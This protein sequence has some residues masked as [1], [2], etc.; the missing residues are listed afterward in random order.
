MTSASSDATTTASS[1]A[2]SSGGYI[3]SGQTATV[4][5]GTTLTDA[6]IVGGGKLIVSGTASGTVL[7][8]TTAGRATEII[9][10]GGIENSVTI[11]AGIVSALSG[12][13]ITE[14]SVLSGGTLIF[15][16]GAQ[17]GTITAGSGG[18]VTISAA[19]IGTLE[20]ESGATATITS[21]TI[22]L[23]AI[24][25]A[26]LT[27]G[28]AT[29]AASLLVGPGGTLQLNGGTATGTVISGASASELILA[30]PTSGGPVETQFDIISGGSQT[31][32][33]GVSVASGTVDNGGTQ[34]VLSTASASHV[35]IASGG[36]QIISSGGI[37][38]DDQIEA[39]ASVLNNG[40]LIFDDQTTIQ[41]QISG[42]GLVEQT[43]AN[44]T[45]RFASGALAAFS[46][47]LSM[48][49]GTV[50]IADG[51]DAS[52]I[53]F[54]FTASG[55]ETLILGGSLPSTLA[56]S[57]FGSGDQIVLS[58]L[59][60]GTSADL[61]N[62][63]QLRIESGGTLIETI[64]LGSGLDYSAAG[65]TLT[66][67]PD[68]N[69][70]ILTLSGAASGYANVVIS[71]GA[72]TAIVTSG[73]G[74]V[75]PT[76]STAIG[77]E[78]DSGG[79]LYV[80]GTGIQTTIASAA[81]ET[82]RSGGTTIQTTVSAGGSTTVLSGGL[83][84]G[85]TL[86]GATQQILG[87]TA[88]GTTVRGDCEGSLYNPA[89]SPGVQIVA[90]G[91][92]ASATLVTLGSAEQ[93]PYNNPVYEDAFQYVE[94]GATVIDTTLTGAHTPWLYHMSVQWSDGQAHE[95]ISAGG[96]AIHTTINV[97]GIMDVQSGGT[98]SATV[99]D[100]G[101]LLLESGAGYSGTLT[102][103]PLTAPSSTSSAGTTGSV[104][105]VT[106]AQIA[107]LT[108][109]GFDA[110]GGTA[111]LYPWNTLETTTEN[112]IN[113]IV[114]SDLT[115]AG[116]SGT[117]DA[118][119]IGPDGALTVTEGS[120]TVT[121]H[122]AGTFG[123]DFY[124]QAAPGGG[125]E[126]TYGV[127]CY[128]PG[129]LIAS[130]NGDRPVQDLSIGD[131]VLTA[132][133]NARPVRWIGR[134]SY[135]GRFARGNPDIMPVMIRP[136]A[137]GNDLPRRTLVV[138]PLHAMALD[139]RLVP[140]RLLLNGTSIVQ[141]RETG[142]VDYIHIELDSHDLVLAE[143]T[144]S[145]TFVDDGSRGMFHNA[146][147]FDALYPDAM[148]AASTESSG[149]FCLPRIEDGPALE[150]LRTRLGSLGQTLAERYR[151][152]GFI[153]VVSPHAIEGWA[154]CDALPDE[155]RQLIIRC[156]DEEIGRVIANRFRADLTENGRFSGKSGFSLTVTQPVPLAR[157]TVAD[158]ESDT[159][160]PHARQPDHKSVA[161]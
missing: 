37:V 104:L 40:T 155:P 160:L 115:F 2:I 84:S 133:G 123:S 66:E 50:A 91:G 138:S 117:T 139:N 145:E 99:I 65:L 142:R 92:I 105:N 131:L 26:T 38:L 109:N 106:A 28:A 81:T 88:T 150:A 153:D 71:S 101:T 137:L 5:A 64:S 48:A 134:R 29:S 42:N 118:G 20:L 96:T 23:S 127:P 45:L 121:L 62:G 46:G 36:Q 102:F 149:L 135:D 78:V 14:A 1:G 41:G 161:A 73:E 52:G 49:G 90:S 57:G 140:A 32:C 58:G 74:A 39:G 112:T 31:I 143:G 159:I 13:I 55:A 56:I 7:R 72:A 53:D 18:A 89:W 148:P 70:A 80:E 30:G 27:L 116:A 132:S 11:N 47:T 151:I 152:T 129:T 108:I 68:G 69:A 144:P 43:G 136:G 10:N 60:S 54:S 34:T 33:F 100:G 87:G 122:L 3:V 77:T 157:L 124:F 21:A 146:A 147:E 130:P 79:R 44:D 93:S 95:I 86:D 110:I 12:G 4:T 83:A 97:G 15:S 61:V 8:G 120:E 22:P 6:T 98:A 126:I 154:R 75:I 59:T 9:A 156:G 103:A 128:C 85:T 76:G 63:S 67:Q 158:Q 114:I 25:G 16:S 125:T 17:A 51:Q 82:I 119:T 35:A 94:N 107:S 24:S 111:R 141:R 19:Q 113:Q